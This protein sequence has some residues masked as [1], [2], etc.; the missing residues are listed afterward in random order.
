MVAGTSRSWWRAKLPDIGAAASRFP[1]AVLI[2]AVFALFKL[3]HDDVGDTETRILAALAASFLCAV[4][5]DFYVESTAQPR[6][7]RVLLW[8]AGSAVIALLFWLAWDLWLIQY[9]FLAGLLLLLAVAGQ[10]G[11]SER[12]ASFWLF[13]HRLWLGAALALIAAVLF[14]AASPSSSRPCNSCSGSNSRR[15]PMTI[16]GP[17]VSVSSRL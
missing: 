15:A 7:L 3:Y 14:G 9:L 8:L 17:S 5:V 4:A 12:N 1:L 16:S 6:S 10:L 2:A 11:R 13:N